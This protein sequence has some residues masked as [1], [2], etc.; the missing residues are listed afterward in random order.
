MYLQDQDNI[1]KRIV[2]LDETTALTGAGVKGAGPFEA[3]RLLS[4]L[5]LISLLVG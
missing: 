3:A 1:W 2:I 4:G 5:R